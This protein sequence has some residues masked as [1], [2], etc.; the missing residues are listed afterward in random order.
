MLFFFSQVMRVRVNKLC[1]GECSESVDVKTIHNLLA[2]EVSPCEG[3]SYV[4]C[5]ARS[6]IPG[7]YNCT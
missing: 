2:R 1:S 3:E 5:L 4:P 7:T 6:F